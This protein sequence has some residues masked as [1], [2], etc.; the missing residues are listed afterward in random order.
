MPWQSGSVEAIVDVI[1]RVVRISTSDGRERTIDLSPARPIAQI[2]S[3]F[4]GDLHALGIT[5][6][7]WDKPQERAD[8]RPFSQDSRPR[9]FDARP[10]TSWFALLTELEA[11][12]DEWRSPFCGRSGVNFWWGGFDLTVTLFN[13]RHAVPRPG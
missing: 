1:D 4:T 2:W 7:L 9:A 10:A 8:V 6:D 13:G 12:F 11:T 5:A 3:E